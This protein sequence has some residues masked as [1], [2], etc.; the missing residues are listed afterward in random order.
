M[1]DAPGSKPDVLTYAFA[2]VHK[3]A[4]GIAVGLVAGL[5]IFGITAFHVIAHPADGPNLG[6]LAQYFFGYGVTWAGA[7][8][9]FGWGLAT[10]FVAGWFMAFVR[11]LVLSIS[12]FAIRTKARMQ[13]T[14]DFLDHI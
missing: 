3:A 11:N 2:P 13:S 4:L 7:F 14:A 10:G 6:L 5:A 12:L 1:T 9:G 8:I